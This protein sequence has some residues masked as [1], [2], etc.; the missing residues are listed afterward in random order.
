MSSES[1][2]RHRCNKKKE[3]TKYIVYARKRS[4]DL[5]CREV[6]L[7]LMQRVRCLYQPHI[8]FLSPTLWFVRYQRRDLAFNAR[9]PWLSYPVESPRPI[10]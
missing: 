1:D 10:C 5:R 9:G 7:H 2:D 3:I 4:L 8:S 6:A